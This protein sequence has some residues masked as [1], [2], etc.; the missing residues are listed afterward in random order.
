M[1]ALSPRTFARL[2]AGVGVVGGTG[3]IAAACASSPTGS[4]PTASGPPPSATV[5][6]GFVLSHEQFTTAE[7]IDQ[8]QRAED[9][10]FQYLWASDHLQPW[11]DNEAHAMFPWL[12]LAVVGQ[13]TS[14]I[15]YGT[16]VTCPIYHYHPATVAQ[17]FASLAMLS[18]QRVFLG[19]G[20]GERL[21]EQAGNRPVRALR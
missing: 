3:G 17:A 19:V 18:P 7:L 12:T 9:A 6:V 4:Q 21:N 16:G 8:A 1:R 5:G 15:S 10:G 14:R 20:T 2:V 13:R 11:Q